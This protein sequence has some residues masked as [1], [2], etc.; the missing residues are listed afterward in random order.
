MQKENIIINSI[1]KKYQTIP[2]VGIYEARRLK[3]IEV[4]FSYKT[5][6]STIEIPMK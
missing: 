6:N 4:E 1:N 2:Y 3:S 5:M